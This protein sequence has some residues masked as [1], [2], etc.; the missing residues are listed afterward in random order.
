MSKNK[1]K[2]FANKDSE[3]LVSCL[4]DKIGSN[5]TEET[6][7]NEHDLTRLYNR[8]FNHYYK[9][10]LDFQSE[11]EGLDSFGEESEFTELKVHRAKHLIRSLKANITKTRLNF[12]PV[13]NNSDNLTNDTARIAKEILDNLVRTRNLESTMK[14]LVEC[15]LV[16]GSG[17]LSCTWS[18]DK[19]DFFTASDDGLISEG[20]VEIQ[21]LKPWEVFYSKH[22]K[23]WDDLDWV[24]VKR[25]RNRWNVIA[26][27]P[28]MKDEILSI[29]NAI[30]EI[31]TSSNDY[32]RLL[33]KDINE[34]E[35]YIFV[36]EFYHKPTLSVPTGRIVFYSGSVI[37]DDLINYY[38]CIPIIP[39]MPLK[40]QGY[41]FGE[42]LYNSM[43]EAQEMI[44]ENLSSIA[45]VQ[46]NLGTP[47]VLIP[48]G[49]NIDVNSLDG[50]RMI[51]YKPTMEKGGGAPSSLDLSST[52]PQLLQMNENLI[53]QLQ[54]ISGINEVLQGQNGNV[55][56]GIALSILSA[57]SV[58]N[59]SDFIA[60]YVISVEKLA[61]QIIKT[62]AK[63]ASSE[64]VVMIS[65]KRN[66]DKVK[67]FIGQDL[68]TITNVRI[69]VGNPVTQTVAGRINTAES[70]LQQGMIK[71]A[72]DYFRVLETGDLDNAVDGQ[73]NELDFILEENNDMM[74]G[75][76]VFA[77]ATDNHA[78][79]IQKHKDLLNSTRIRREKPEI[80]KRVMEHILEHTNLSGSVDPKLIHMLSTGQNPMLPAEQTTEVQPQQQAPQ[81]AP[82]EEEILP[83]PMDVLE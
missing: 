63:F 11:D 76:Q 6:R 26:Q 74:N 61:T 12:N 57:N 32:N 59:L 73:T 68:S 18:Q 21:V 60:S 71:N 66:N 35:D 1:D 14:E 28:D 49:S 24:V 13:S 81:Q 10:L 78:Y 17:F 7:T 69:N 30:D 54:N 37:L 56:S 4:L 77:L 67:S 75:Q 5:E 41:L 82:M 31:N 64:R 33:L 65:G 58:E 83:N 19:G 8:C 50:L 80:M 44:D 70:L 45:S 55:S 23:S 43:I 27:Y 34:D 47:N 36:N 51:S 2:Y 72:Q 53:N 3:E 15:G 9:G 62:Y 20:D 29:P 40:V 39:Y 48:Q 46:K 52:N 42:P 79:H 22:A 25:L 16:F 38:E